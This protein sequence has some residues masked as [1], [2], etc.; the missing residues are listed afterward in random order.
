[1]PR[2]N[3]RPFLGRP[4]ISYSIITAKESA[5]FDRVVVST[6]DEE[7]AEVAQKWGADILMRPRSLA[8]DP[9]VGTQEVT[10]HAL[11]SIPCHYACC[12]YATAPTMRATDLVLARHEHLSGDHDY[13]YVEGWLYWGRAKTFLDGVGF[14][15]SLKMRVP[16]YRYIDINTSEDWARAEEMYQNMRPRLL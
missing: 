15:H 7:V 10:A 6:E 16:E 4:I 11:R 13:V 1:V 9:Q 5:L 8:D 2:K 12:I 14:D 3:V